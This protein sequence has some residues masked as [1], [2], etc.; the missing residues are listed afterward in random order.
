[1]ENLGA[2]PYTA[3]IKQWRGEKLAQAFPEYDAA[4]L[5]QYSKSSSM[6][7]SEGN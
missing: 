2:K 5:I 3:R 6:Q 7:K 4:V 1:M